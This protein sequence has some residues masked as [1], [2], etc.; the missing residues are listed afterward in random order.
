ML[1][2]DPRF[3][4]R[5]R[6]LLGLSGGRDSVAMFHT[7]LAAGSDKLVVC[8]LNHQLRGLFSAHD[9]AFVRELA[10]KH[11]LP[12]EIA[13]CPVLQRAE[14]ESV[15]VEVAARRARHEF[16]AGCAKKHRCNQVLLAHHAD[17]CAETAVL[18]LL[19]GSAGLVGMRFESIVTVDRK[20]LTLIRPLLGVRRSEID[21]YLTERNLAY[22]DDASNLEPFTA[23][24]RL[25]LEALPLLEEM[26]ARDVVPAINRA[27]EAAQ[28]DRET[29]DALLEILELIDPQDRLFL[30]KLR[31]L[32]VPLQRRALFVYLHQFGIPDLS[33][34][35]LTRC[36][37]LLDPAAPAK[38]N[39]PGDFHL[40]RRA[41]RLFVE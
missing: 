16:F 5:R 29:L 9:A 12:F 32:P 33:R 19:R 30:P 31:K 39:L 40:R 26:M 18:N 3:A 36:L 15:S 10:E 25:R 28:E 14:E 35:L 41:G 34:D 38:M 11:D 13:R 1:A 17:D 23:R 21:A 20:K 7:L 24:N 37:S 22:R 27:A 2:L 6:Y 8:H 4:P